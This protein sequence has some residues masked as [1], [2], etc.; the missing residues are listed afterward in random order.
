MAE[1]CLECWNEINETNDKKE[2]YIFTQNL[3]LCEGCGKWKKTI[4]IERKYLYRYIF[5]NVYIV[6]RRMCRI[7]KL[8]Y[9]VYK[10]HKS[11]DK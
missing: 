1:F 9:K 10:E 3:E 7:I 4:V 6:V 5:F 11:K 2:K 8:P